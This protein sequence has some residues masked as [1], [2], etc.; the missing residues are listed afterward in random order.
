MSVATLC[1]EALARLTLAYILVVNPVILGSAIAVEGADVRAELVSATALAAAFGC[2]LMGALGRESFAP[3]AGMGL[4]A[5]FAYEVCGVRGVPWSTAL[6]AVFL[7]GL[8][9]L[10]FSVGLQALGTPATW[11]SAI[12]GSRL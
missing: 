5:W 2:P 1:G 12:T 7:S 6:G 11:A 8:A 4:N 3:A 9:F 10:L